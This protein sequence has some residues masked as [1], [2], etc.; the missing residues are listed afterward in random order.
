MTYLQHTT[1]R[2]AKARTPRG[3]KS[4]DSSST[5]SAGVGIAMIMLSVIHTVDLHTWK[6]SWAPQ[7]ARETVSASETKAPVVA[8]NKEECT[9]I[10]GKSWKP[11]RAAAGVV[12]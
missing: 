6:R 12:G 10:D 5:L 3:T 1:P 7:G 8:M 4:Y 11:G 9:V 2:S